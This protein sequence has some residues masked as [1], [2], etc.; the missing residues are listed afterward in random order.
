MIS[1][2]S[3]DEVLDVARVEDIVGETVELRR[4]GSNMI[5]LCPF[6]NEKTPSFH[7]SPSKNIYKCFGCGKGGRSIDFL[8]DYHKMTFVEA[9]RY[10]AAKYNIHLEETELTDDQKQVIDERE[11]YFAINEFA[12][13][14]YHKYA[15]ESD[16]G[17]SIA[18]AYFESRKIDMESVK[19]FQLG[20]A[21]REGD[22]FVKAALKAGFSKEKLL[23]LGLMSKS[24]KDFFVGRIIFPI[25]NHRGRI[26]GFAGRIL[27]NNKKLPKYINSI[28]SPVY[29]KREILYGAFDA[30]ISIRQKDNCI[31]AEGYT[32]IIGM[33]QYGIGNV[34]ATSGT[35]LTDEQIELIKRHTKNVLFL[36]DGDDAGVNAALRGVEKIITKDMNVRVAILP[37]KEDPDSYIR[38]VGHDEFIGFLDRNSQDFLLFKANLSLAQVQN[39]PTGK[40]ELLHEIIDLIAQMP[41]PL[42]RNVYAGEM[43][44]LF[45][46]DIETIRE[47]ITKS[48]KVLLA[49]RGIEE[50][51]KNTSQS[52]LQIIHTEKEKVEKRSLDLYQEKDIVRVL[53]V[54]GNMPVEAENPESLALFII[55]NI[56]DL[57]EFFDEESYKKI[58]RECLDLLE[59]DKKI[60]ENHWFN[61]DDKDI[62]DL[63]ISFTSTPYY[64][65]HMWEERW[66]IHLYSQ[67][68]PDDNFKEDAIQAI[69]RFRMKKLNKLIK[70]NQEKLKEIEQAGATGA[71]LIALLK[72]DIF[73]KDLRNEVARKMNTVI[74]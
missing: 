50:N 41:D 48:L 3:I 62:R 26:A 46:V 34:V 68:M 38:K 63:Y 71:E 22:E 42:K 43:A 52:P 64:Y 18:L 5:G 19:K 24:E 58:I 14:F 53:M 45:D 67:P 16:Y 60:P 13:N 10:I 72:A 23:E 25:K 11:T 2:K 28:E 74:I 36:F 6:H 70:K 15:L 54:F 4:R 51:K 40:S 21:P 37:D 20:F 65:S 35:S 66:Q 8:L 33:H 56:K 55:S 32:D 29:I 9:V 44:S 47:A 27:D 17:K 30:R 31:L 1:R 12:A 69:M 59:K 73:Y 49:K 61:H 57:L 39:D 7:V